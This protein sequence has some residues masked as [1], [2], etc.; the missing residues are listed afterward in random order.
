[1][2]ETEKTVDEPRG[3]SGEYQAIVMALMFLT[4]IPTPSIPYHP[5]LLG[6]A[7]LYFPLVG[8][9]IGVIGAVIYSAALSL[10]PSSVAVALAIIAMYLSTG[11]FHEDGLADTADG[12]GGGW[13]VEDKLRIMKDSR[14]GTYGTLAIAGLL[15]VKFSALSQ[16]AAEQIPT[17]LIVA[18]V[19]ARWSILPMIMTTPYVRAEGTG[20]PF[21]DSISPK[22]FV[23]A[24]LFV[25]GLIVS[26][27]SVKTL[28]LIISC[29]CLLTSCRWYFKRKLGGIT[30]DTLGATNQLVEVAVYLIFLIQ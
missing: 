20:K 28:L 23:I 30:G 5:S 12:I 16:M 8:I 3:I 19:L 18:H 10:W 17:V 29:L 14:I 4:R 24:T 1:M 27:A 6:K 11:G 15:L 25:L 22:R 7:T 21:V 26:L 13:T 9:V 2:T